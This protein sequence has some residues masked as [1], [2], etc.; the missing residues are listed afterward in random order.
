MNHLIAKPKAKSYMHI[1]PPTAINVTSM[2]L[3]PQWKKKT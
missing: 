3:I 1:V 2:D